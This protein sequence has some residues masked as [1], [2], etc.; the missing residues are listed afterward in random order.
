MPDATFEVYPRRYSDEDG[1]DFDAAAGEPTGEFG[2]RFRDA[3]GEIQTVSKKGYDSREEATR[4]IVDFGLAFG[5]AIGMPEVSTALAVGSRTM[6]V[7]SLA[8]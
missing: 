3:N 6:P 2:W 5:D 7:I 1:G 8:E 4:A